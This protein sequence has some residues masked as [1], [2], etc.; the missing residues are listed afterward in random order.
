MA[1]KLFSPEGTSSP[2][3]M[4]AWQFKIL[5]AELQLLQQHAADPTCPCGL[6]DIQ[7]WCHSKHLLSVCALAWETA[8]MDHDPEHHDMLTQLGDEANELHMD[9]RVFVVNPADSKSDVNLVEWSRNWR[10]KL[11]LIYYSKEMRKAEVKELATT[12]PR[13]KAAQDITEKSRRVFEAYARDAGNWGGNP[14]VG[15]NVGGSKEERGNLTQLKRAG[16]ITTQVDE[17]NTWISFTPD[18]IQYAASLGID[19]SWIAKHRQVWQEQDTP[20]A[21]GY[22]VWDGDGNFVRRSATMGNLPIGLEQAIGS[23]ISGLGWALGAALA[24]FVIAMLTK[25]REKEA[26]PQHDENAMLETSDLLPM[27]DG[28][29][30]RLGV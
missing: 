28:L 24:G 27:L 9:M 30:K 12:K 3:Q 26:K 18:G 19:L 11:E 6:A 23:T 14:L 1:N 22:L 5:I 7:E 25:K 21:S 17:G 13:A 2:A 29:I 15:G 16:L 4:I 10:K 20:E 8:S